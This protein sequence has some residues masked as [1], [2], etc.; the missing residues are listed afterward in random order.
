MT[1]MA[2]GEA[3]ESTLRML[4][5]G[6]TCSAFRSP[7]QQRNSLSLMS[8]NNLLDDHQSINVLSVLSGYLI[9]GIR[10]GIHNSWLSNMP[11]WLFRISGGWDHRKVGV[12][13][14]A[15]KLQEESESDVFEDSVR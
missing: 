6:G 13:L 2:P 10:V 12:R 8:Q 15:C 9:C 5:S 1:H 7:W 11:L 14:L 3:V 4:K